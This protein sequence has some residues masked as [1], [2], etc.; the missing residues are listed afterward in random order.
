MADGTTHIAAIDR[1]GNLIALTPSGGVFRKSAFAPELGCTLSTRSEMFVLEDGHPN[2]LA[3]G[4][5]PRTTLVSYLISEHGV[6]TTTVG[7]PGGDD[8]AQAD[9]QI[10]LNL[11]IFGMNPQQAVEAP[12][13][14]TQT[15]VNSFYPRAYKP[16]VLNVEPGIPAGTRAE[17]TRARPHRQRD[18]RLRRGRGGDATRSGDR[19][20]VR[21]GG[22]APADLRA[23]LVACGRSPAVERLPARPLHHLLRGDLHRHGGLRGHLA[24][25][26]ALRQ[27]AGRL[28][29][30][31]GLRLRRLP[32]AFT[33]AVLPL[34]M[35]VDRIGKNWLIVTVAMFVLALAS[36]LMA[37]AS[38][39]TML[40]LARGLQGFAS[41]AAWVASQP[42]IARGSGGA[43][44]IDSREMS[45]VTIAA[46]LGVIA[47]PLLGGV[48]EIETPFLINAALA[49]FWGVAALLFLTRADTV[50]PGAKPPFRD[51]LRRKGIVIACVAIFCSCTCFGILELLLPLHLDRLGY[52]KLAIGLFFGVFSVL[53]V[54]AQPLISRWID[55]RGGYEPIYV[56]SLGL[57]VMMVLVIHGAGRRRIVGDAGA[58]RRLQRGALPRVHVRGRP[59]Q[60]GGPARQRLRPLESRLLAGLSG[61]PHRRGRSLQ[62]VRPAHGVSRLRRGAAGGNGGD[63]PRHA[64]A[65]RMSFA[66][67]CWAMGIAGS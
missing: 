23:R 15:L 2:A 38:S 33:L 48:G 9:L 6:P 21:R 4:K 1:D 25:H 17:L 27:D 16:G 18:R 11:L 44:E 47:G 20:A 43:S 34:G 67:T 30:P 24:Q 35:L 41:A 13:F 37:Y 52:A 66:P 31:D 10:V 29:R 42:L 49:F 55:A 5:R 26:P 14:S 63:L 58:G 54:A 59:E 56:G 8:Q 65:G 39:V 61:R 40:V 57:A 36:V 28:G 19:R 3:P 51:L 64:R 22:S 46:G 7:C 53:Y 45:L 60:R 12:R 62:P 50:A 32:I